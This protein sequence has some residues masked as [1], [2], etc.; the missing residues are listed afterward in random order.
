MGVHIDAQRLAAMPA[1][2]KAIPVV[3]EIRKRNWSN[4]HAG[5]KK[6]IGNTTAIEAGLVIEDWRTWAVTTV[7]RRDDDVGHDEIENVCH[8]RQ[9]GLYI[10]VLT[11]RFHHKLTGQLDLI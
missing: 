2:L 11:P 3:I 4:P 5:T 7:T 1:T 6:V 10:A 8:N 9:T